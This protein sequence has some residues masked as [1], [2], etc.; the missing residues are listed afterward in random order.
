MTLKPVAGGGRPVGRVY[1]GLARA[2]ST[3]GGIN[4]RRLRSA[5]LPLRGTRE[6][7]AP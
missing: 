1:E 7:S 6:T 3:K 5:K 4:I 2:K